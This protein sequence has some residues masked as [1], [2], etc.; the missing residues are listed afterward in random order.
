[1]FFQ[2]GG[3]DTGGTLKIYGDALCKVRLHIKQIIM[4]SAGGMVAAGE[5][6][7]NEGVPRRK[8]TKEG[9]NCIK[10]NKNSFFWL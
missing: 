4:V 10:N 5:K 9:E 1:M 7:N 6:M 3:P 2:D 8:I